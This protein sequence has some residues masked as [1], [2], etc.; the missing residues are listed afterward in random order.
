MGTRV[1]NN[2]EIHIEKYVSNHNRYH[3]SNVFFQR[4]APRTALRIRRSWKLEMFTLPLTESQ[5]IRRNQYSSTALTRAAHRRSLPPFKLTIF[6][7][8][9][10]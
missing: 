4:T 9:S 10:S 6:K 3:Y 7:A 1:C 2:E 8:A 5:I